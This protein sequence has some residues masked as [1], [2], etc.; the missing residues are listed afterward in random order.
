VTQPAKK[1]F[2]HV[3]ISEM[4]GSSLHGQV[5]LDYARE[6]LLWALDTPRSSVLVD[7]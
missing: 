5:T 4:V 3:V 1:G 7:G 6:G 2:G